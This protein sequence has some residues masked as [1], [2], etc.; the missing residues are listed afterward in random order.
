MCVPNW[1][2]S[3]DATLICIQRKR[4]DGHRD[5][6][7]YALGRIVY[8]EISETLDLWVGEKRKFWVEIAEREREISSSRFWLISQTQNTLNLYLRLLIYRFKRDFLR[9][10]RFCLT[11]ERETTTRAS[12]IWRDRESRLKQIF[13]ATKCHCLRLKLH[14]LRERRDKKRMRRRYGVMEIIGNHLW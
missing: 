7:S 4:R 11:F 2:S 9:F 12:K 10:K 6:R 3:F 14:L 8:C 13:Y 5:T 1:L